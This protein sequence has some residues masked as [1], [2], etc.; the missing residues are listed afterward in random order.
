MLS[1]VHHS[2]YS[3]VTDNPVG[4]DQV[5][6]EQVISAEATR[7]VLE[8]QLIRWAKKG[9]TSPSVLNVER[10][11]FRNTVAVAV[12]SF[13]DGKP[14]QKIDVL[15]DG[16]TTVNNNAK[17]IRAAGIAGLLANNAVYT[18]TMWEDRVWHES[19][20]GAA[21]GGGGAV[22]SFNT[23]V[24]AVVPQAGDYTAAQVGA[25]PTS[26]LT[27]PDPHPQYVL[28]AEKAVASGIPTLDGSVHVPTAQLGTGVADNTK[29]LR[30]DQTWQVPPGGG[31]SGT[32][33]SQ[34]DEVPPA[35]ANALDDEFATPG[36]A[37]AWTQVNWA[38]LTLSDVDT[39]FA[40]A[41]FTRN[42]VNANLVRAIMK[43]IPAGDFTIFTQIEL[44]VSNGNFTKAGIIIADGVTAGAGNQGLYG[45]GGASGALQFQMQLGNS[46]ITQTSN[47]VG[48]VTMDNTG[49]NAYPKLCVRVRRV[50]TNYFFGVSFNGVMWFEFQAN[51]GFVPTHFGLFTKNEGGVVLCEHAFKY[52]RYLPSG[53]I[54]NVTGGKILRTKA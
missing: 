18:F 53:T 12:V 7:N 23:R 49:F 27:D 4:I 31:G 8:K 5:T 42:H 24:G 33:S 10:L 45:L 46:Y 36:L 29:F 50:G 9:D 40:N 2:S 19:A 22:T 14:G 16:Q 17:I 41:L 3:R 1:A 37:G 34:D 47:I 52:F 32:F 43:A 25:V 20:G 21:G 28:D 51:L 54:T 15:G 30:G 26:H 11:K 39:T 38:G 44:N 35:V 13:D 6:S 48:P